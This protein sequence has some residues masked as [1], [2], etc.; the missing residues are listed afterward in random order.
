M[1][2]ARSRR[3]AARQ[4]LPLVA[5]LDGV[6]GF[7]G[8]ASYPAP[9]GG[10]PLIGAAATRTGQGIW[11]VTTSGKVHA[12]GDAPDLG[13]LDT[14]LAAPVAGMTATAEGLGYW[15]FAADGTV[16]AFGSA[17]FHGGTPALV[18]GEQIVSLTPT[19]DDGGYWLVTN[20]GKVFSYGNAHPLGSPLGGG[21]AAPV[22]AIVASQSGRGYWVVAANGAVFPFGDAARLGSV[23]TLDPGDHV[24]GLAPTADGAGYWVATAAGAVHP[25]GTARS[26]GRMAGSGHTPVIG[27]AADAAGGYWLATATTP[28]PPPPPPPAPAPPAPA[29]PHVVAQPVVARPAPHV[30]PGGIWA[31]IRQHESGNNYSENTGNGYYGAYQFSLATWRSV[32]GSG[33]PSSAPPAEQDMRAQML[34]A[35]SGWGQWSTARMCGAPV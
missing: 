20:T 18:N 2:S 23:T 1:H 32:G 16:V 34:Q 5:G 31:C 21:L 22:T 13:G 11:S 14:P 33:L 9:L 29:R 35:R 15:V 3:V 12:M 4:A 24:V 8:L 6:I 10:E 7:G 27:I 26:L 25:F 30:A 17:A 28:L 19:A